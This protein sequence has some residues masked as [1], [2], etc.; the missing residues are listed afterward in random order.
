[1][2]KRVH[3]TTGGTSTS[4]R[5]VAARTLTTA[6]SP[7]CASGK[8]SIARHNIMTA[9]QGRCKWRPTCRDALTSSDAARRGRDGGLKS[10]AWQWRT[11]CKSRS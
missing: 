4:S 8:V 7:A 5:R 10:A 2:E 3:R 6:S 9:M 1:M 11:L